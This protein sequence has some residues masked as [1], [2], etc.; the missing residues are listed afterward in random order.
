MAEDRIF[1]I[2]VIQGNI[3]ISRNLQRKTIRELELFVTAVFSKVVL[4]SILKL[5]YN[6]PVND[7]KTEAVQKNDFIS[8]PAIMELMR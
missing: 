4:R 6:M 7:K 3:G 8:L 5:E 1:L 2:S